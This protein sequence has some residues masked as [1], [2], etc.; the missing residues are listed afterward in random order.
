MQALL[1]RVAG[2]AGPAV[3]FVHGF[4]ADRLSWLAVAPMLGDVARIWAVD[5]P[6][7]G[8]A[9][10]AVGDGRA[11]SLAA[12]VQATLAEIAGPVQL[13]GHSLGGLVALHLAAKAPERF[14]ILALIAPAGVGRR[15]DPAFLRAFPKLQTEAETQALLVQ[16]VARPRHIAPVM[17]HHVRA[18]L[19]RPERREGL[20]TIAEALIAEDPLP[21]PRLDGITVLWGAEDR[22]IPPPAD[23][24][25]PTLPGVGHIPQI[26]AAS[27]VQRA[28]RAEIARGLVAAPSAIKADPA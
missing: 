12:A 25:T 23:L 17:V 22:I 15:A 18:A 27:A 10:D 11:A 2:D 13:V 20:V 9:S 16:M 7:H 3:V 1:H 28:L 24:H 14:S 4:G 6:G 19:I 26:E 8:D 5:L 21:L